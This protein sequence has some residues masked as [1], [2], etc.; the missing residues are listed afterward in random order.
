[1]CG[2]TGIV[3]PHLAGGSDAA[4]ESLTANV[5]A[6][7]AALRHRGPDAGGTFV[8]SAAGLALGHRRLAI[9]DL[10]ERGAQP[11]HSACGRYV[12]VFNGEIYN[13]S[14]LRHELD[15]SG[16]ESWRG[17]SDTE[18]LLACFARW[19]VAATLKK[20]V[21]MFA[22]ALCDRAERKLTL[23][24]DRF[25]EKPLYYGFV[26]SGAGSALVFGSELKA[27]RAHASFNQGVDRGALALFLRFS[28]VPCPYSIYENI[29]K[30]QPGS[31]ATLDAS[32]IAART[33]RIEPYWRYEDVARAG[34]ADQIEDEGEG[35]EALEA[36]LREAIGLQLVADV[37]VGAFLSGGIDSSTIVALMQAQS[38]RKVKTFT[39]GFDEAGFNEAPHAAAV[40]HH[41]GTEHTEIR[42]A[43]EDTRAVVPKLPEMYDEPFG[44]SSQIPTSIVCAAARREVTVALSGDAGDELLGGYNRYVIGPKL[45]RALAPPPQALRHLLGEV[46]GNMPRWGWTG[47]QL[48]PALGRGLAPFVDKAYKLGP[49]LGEMQG[50]DDLYKA[51][52]TEWTPGQAP[53]LRASRFKSAIDDDSRYADIREAEHRMMLLDG[54]TYLPDDILTKV[55]RAAMAVSLETRVPLLDHRVAAVAWRLPMRM[56]IRDGKSKWALRQ[57]LYRHVPQSLV[58]RP[59]AGFAIPVGQWLRG[60]LADWAEALLDESRLRA[61]GY[62]DC[63]HV[64]KLWTE[65]RSGTRDWTARL[66]N[67]LMFQAWLASQS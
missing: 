38:A 21:G 40:A 22:L 12:I 41:L 13:H 17:T 61:E 39:V 23:A 19:G 3:S 5:V 57:I 51:L 50:V 55:D 48:A 47:L 34:L 63:D 64:R 9:L 1:M 43:A 6:M 60:P 53:A 58:E 44:D 52:V 54:L 2:I 10:S 25:G 46:I 32:D 31:I 15:A 8:D 27:L 67:V 24:R 20:S 7:T 18:T 35:L 28:Y 26:G 33:C 59:K 62:L 49:A 42:V 11:M 16:A 66:W 14:A 4:T 36:A 56:K 65:H 29:F 45:W 30:L 37:P